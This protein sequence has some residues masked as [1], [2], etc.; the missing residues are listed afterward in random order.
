MIAYPD[1]SFLCSLYREQDFSAQALA[2]YRGMREVLHASSLL[3]FEF[4]QAIELQVF[5]FSQDRKRGYSRR[6]AGEMIEKWETYKAEGKVKL[7]PCDTDEVIRYALELSRSHTAG[8]GHRSLD[9][10]HLATA[11][12]LGAKEFLS[13]DDRQVKLARKLGLATPLV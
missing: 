5:L 4:L 11:V 10:L 3:E 7:V 6:E 9:L 13:F 1:T 12:H 2:H 8:G